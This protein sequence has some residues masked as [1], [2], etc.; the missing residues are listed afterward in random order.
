MS[1]KESIAQPD[2]RARRSRA[3]I[4]SA[5]VRLLGERRWEAIRIEDIAEAADVARS[6]F[7]QHFGSKE[8][9][10][11]ASMQPM[12]DVLGNAGDPAER[13]RLDRLMQHYWSNRSL[14]RAIFCG[15]RAAVIERAL[16]DRI[17]PPDSTHESTIVAVR[18]AAGRT[19]LIAAWVR[20][21]FSASAPKLADAVAACA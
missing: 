9:L 13:D 19:A 18:V 11:L 8:A 7:Y 4:L 12:L 14:A 17:N 3:A 16:R 6:T 20:G 10:L 15:P 1:D 5:F 21:D 2:R